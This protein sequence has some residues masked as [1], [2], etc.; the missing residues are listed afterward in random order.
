MSTENGYE[1]PAVAGSG[2]IATGFAAA[3]SILG[4]VKLLA[5]SDASAWRAEEKAQKAATKL[6]GG[7]PSH[8]KVTTELS[9]LGDCDLIVEAIVE[10]LEHKSALLKE[11]AEGVP[12]AD[13]ATTTSSL[14]IGE[15]ALESGLQ[16]RLYGL[17][18][19]NPVPRMELIELCLPPGLDDG[20]AERARAFCEALGKTG[21]EVADKAGFVVNRLLFPFLFDAVRLME[22]HDLTPADV[23]TCMNLGAGHPMGPLRLIDFVGLDVSAAIGESLYAETGNDEH[24]A[25]KKLQELIDDGRLG[26]KAGK[27]FYDY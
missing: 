14:Q 11:V 23:D 12:G 24:R 21:V 7:D 22:E 26:R 16:S 27:G 10:D 18:V 17:H 20:I 6:E 19:F 4:E 13:L 25:P 15:I 2:T 5:R 8:I 9:E 1:R 3:A